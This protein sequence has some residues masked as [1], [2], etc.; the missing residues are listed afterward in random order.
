VSNPAERTTKNTK[1]ELMTILLPGAI[2]EL[3]ALV[4]GSSSMLGRTDFRTAAL[5]VFDALALG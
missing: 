2:G 4:D 3:V 5:C 1:A